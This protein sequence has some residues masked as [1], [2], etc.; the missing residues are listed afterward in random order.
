V[1]SEASPH[2]SVC[3][4]KEGNVDVRYDS[5]C[6]SDAGT[7]TDY[8]ETAAIYNINYDGDQND[9]ECIGK[10]W[11]SN[12]G[13]STGSTP[14]C[15]GD[16]STSDDWATYSGSLTSSTSLSCRRCLNGGDQGT[17]ALYGNGHISGSTCYYG[18]IA[19]SGSSAE[20]G[21]SCT[22]GSSDI[23]GD[24][25]ACTDCYPYAR[26]STTSCYTS[27]TS[28][29]YCVPAAHCDGTTCYADLA[30]GNVCDEDSDCIS[31]DCNPSA[32]G[33][34]YCTASGY[35]CATTSGSGMN[36]GDRDCYN[37]D[38]YRC[39][40]E[41]NIGVYIDCASVSSTDSDG[42]YAYTT[43]GYV[44]DTNNAC[45]GTSCTVTYRRDY[46]SGSGVYDYYA[47][48]TS[49]GSD[50][51]NCNDYDTCVSSQSLFR[52]YGCIDTTNDYCGY[53]DR[54]RDGASSYCTTSVGACDSQI[55][56]SVYGA[57][58]GDDDNIID[59]FWTVNVGGC[60]GYATGAVYDTTKP[61]ITDI[62]SS[63]SV[64]YYYN[65]TGATTGIVYFNSAIA[66]GQAI[67][68]T[69]FWTDENSIYGEDDV[70]AIKVSGLYGGKGESNNVY[71]SP[72]TL[73][74]TFNSGDSNGTL[75]IYVRDAVWLNDT[76]SITFEEDLTLPDGT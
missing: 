46:C 10:T 11:F 49:Y 61:I 12:L 32:S 63:T 2:S 66:D 60:V 36:T 42:R 18:N 48:G 16:D 65:K 22:L 31:N 56:D 73:T 9:C 3:T 43:G 59:Y 41:N 40:S 39:N 68:F 20:N 45:S 64:D 34:S 55:W 17:V 67:T 33:T 53:T 44:S 25:V 8:R 30:N 70:K 26:S 23:C 38:I 5:V 72:G 27:C 51:R 13:S 1:G 35:E 57:C 6:T 69:V 4:V 52:D 21:A 15:C 24:N 58:C 37:N 47:S 75:D 14:W 71:P 62:S 54:D 29:S 50:W 76:K 7:V 19:C 28:D 74:Y